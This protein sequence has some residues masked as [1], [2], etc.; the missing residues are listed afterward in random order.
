MNSEHKKLTPQA[1]HLLPGD[2]QRD[3]ATEVTS[4]LPLEQAWFLQESSNETLPGLDESNFLAFALPGTTKKKTSK[5][6]LKQKNNHPEITLAMRIEAEAQELRSSFL[7]ETWSSD[8]R[9][10]LSLG[11]SSLWIGN[12]SLTVIDLEIRP[13]YLPFEEQPQLGH[14]HILGRSQVPT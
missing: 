4:C 3:T 11:V 1:K 10:C 5:K 7:K 2:L 12:S 9:L 14:S 6:K 8:S 13:R